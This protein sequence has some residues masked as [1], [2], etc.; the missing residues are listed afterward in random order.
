MLGLPCL[1]PRAL[2]YPSHPKLDPRPLPSSP[3]TTDAESNEGSL[4]R[5]TAKLHDGARASWPRSTERQRKAKHRNDGET[6]PR[7]TTASRTRRKENRHLCGA[8]PSP[9]TPR[10]AGTY[11]VTKKRR[12]IGLLR[13]DL[14]TQNAPSGLQLEPRPTREP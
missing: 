13:R 5:P 10:Q 14:A 3:Q 4:D 1:S 7:D 11:K 6:H 12:N 8:S 9:L 2:L